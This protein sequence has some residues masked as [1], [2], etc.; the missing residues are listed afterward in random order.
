MKQHEMIMGVSYT[1]AFICVVAFA[2]CAIAAVCLMIRDIIRTF[3][4]GKSVKDKQIYRS[5][6]LDGLSKTSDK[7][8]VAYLSLL[9]GNI[10]EA[11]EKLK[12]LLLDDDE[13]FGSI[14]EA[15]DE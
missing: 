2:I 14:K 4:H 5:G 9:N 11:T 6:Y 12:E 7:V 3:R 13:W 8:Q 1:I 10:D 15:T